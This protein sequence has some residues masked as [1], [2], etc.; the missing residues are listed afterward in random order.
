MTVL[1]PFYNLTFALCSLSCKSNEQS[2]QTGL[3]K[4]WIVW[5]WKVYAMPPTIQLPI[6]LR[7]VTVQFCQAHSF[8]TSASVWVKCVCFANC[9][10]S[11]I[12]LPFVPHHL[13]SGTG[14]GTR[15]CSANLKFTHINKYRQQHMSEHSHMQTEFLAIV[16]LVSP[17]LCQ[18]PHNCTWQHRICV[19]A[20][21]VSYLSNR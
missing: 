3:S 21:Q 2:G 16:L 12:S 8:G 11:P 17:T 6:L 13:L 7:L 20:D 19:N 14:T 9:H 18:P 4:E 5:I 1:L 15:C 10:P